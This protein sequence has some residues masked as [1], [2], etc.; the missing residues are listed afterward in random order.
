M[1]ARGVESGVHEDPFEILG[2]PARFD[3][4]EGTLQRA[5]LA[6]AAA[7]HPDL[8][9]DQGEGDVQ[10]AS[11]NR[12]KSMLADPERRANALL[13]RVGGP[14]KGQDKSLPAGFLV[15][16]METREAVEEALSSKDAA[17]RE[18]WE[19]W[20]QE[21]REEYQGRVSRL[22]DAL[23]DSRDPA[24]LRAIRQ[25]LNAW[26]YIERLIEQLDP[27]YDPARRDFAD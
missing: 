14:G 23:S 18:K 5:Y 6:R 10:T 7:I 8:G 25:E 15:S 24:T 4:D 21:Q 12:A 19:A 11:L 20:A 13:E 16:I 17:Q 2:L 27:H 26:R 1:R 9:A 22:F 3:L